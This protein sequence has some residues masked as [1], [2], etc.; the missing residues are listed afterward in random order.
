MIGKTLGHYEILEKIGQGGM[1][2][3][4]RARDT[5]LG[6]EV[7]LKTLPSAKSGDLNWRTRFQREAMAVAA[8]KHPNIVTI[9]SVEE[10]G[11]T[12]F[13][14]MEL[15][16]GQSLDYLI[17]PNG[18]NLPQLLDIAIPV[19]Q[20][21]SYAHEKGIMHRDLK[22][23]NIMRDER[24][25]LKVLDFGLAKLLEPEEGSEAATL[26]GDGGVTKEGAVI[27]TAS[28]M[29]PEQAEGKSTDARSDIFSLGILL[30]EMATGQKPFKGDTTI[31]TI[32][33]VLKDNPPL[34][35]HLN[36]SL[37]N[38]L[39]R[40]VNR[41]LAKDPGRR[42]QVALDLTNELE[43]L[44][45]ESSS[46]ESV[47]EERIA[48]SPPAVPAA[49]SAIV[50]GRSSRKR[51]WIGGGAA[52]ALAVVLGLWQPWASKDASSTGSQTQTA[53]VASSQTAR[54]GDRMMAV[55]FP[56]ENLGPSDQA[57]FA[58]GVSE[59]ITSR[60]SAVSGLGVI[61]R[62]SAV[63]YDRSGK[64]LRQVGSEL[65]VD[66][67]L[68]GTV[69]W[70]RNA[71]G[72]QRVR[73]TPQLIRAADDTRIWSESY[74]R[75]IDDIFEVQSD[76]AARVITE[77][78]VTLLGSESERLEERPT[79]NIEA[80]QA[81]LQAKELKS[82]TSSLEEFDR[83]KVSLL[84]KAT[85]LDPGFLAAWFELA[86]HH[87]GR[88]IG[89][90]R[91]ETRL[92]RA[93]EAVE[94]AEAVDPNHPFALLARGY[95]YYYG[96][97]DYDR[98]LSKFTAAS[99]VLPND[100]D[101]LEAIAYIHRRQ[102]K[103]EQAV[104]ELE[105]VVALDPENANVIG[106]LALTYG[107]LRRFEP[108]SRLLDRRLELE[109][110]NDD[111]ALQKAMALI[112]WKGDVAGARSALR[113]KP[114][115]NPIYLY[116]RWLLDTFE[117]DYAKALEHAERVEPSIPFIRV[118]RMS[119]VAETKVRLKGA[120]GASES[121]AELVRACEELL[122][123][124]PSNTDVRGWLAIAHAHLGEN[125]AAVSE[126]KLAVELEAKDL[127]SG[128]EQLVTLARVYSLV[129]R[130]EEAVELL[131]RLLATNYNGALTVPMLQINPDW[132]A[133]REDPGFVA[134]LEK[135]GE[136]LP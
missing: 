131:D 2:E 133:L 70:A 105:N 7:A 121:L 4:Y 38:H 95:Y 115:S 49:D 116:G 63:Q 106:T 112:S 28:Y 87:S 134:L 13:L 3:V 100:T 71:D 102:G 80:Y 59:E 127:F 104:E 129:G 94:F 52:L 117:R 39:G 62:T 61:S 67:V 83:Q 108:A 64:T 16:E 33:S 81:Y 32:S 50:E 36:H 21:V 74:D 35:T 65:G 111:A 128:P 103:L 54:N 9:H 34:V 110:E 126:A 8:L 118:A 11:E 77:L 98:A 22:P 20:A 55:V 86:V 19:V 31:S 69:R 40:V 85:T 92:I 124:S 48:V 60:L 14:T 97:R 68:E 53:A 76:I 84:E 12:L 82:G 73:I 90:D 26:V 43:G 96:F 130:K 88:Y 125:S 79:D 10:D 57:Y 132:D 17:P 42:Y 109:P 89:L 37:P 1:G 51:L 25:H 58:A 107:A 122:E 99:E 5:K 120:D 136:K 113:E 72:T 18:L 47:I 29:S 91:T 44:R 75:Q 119:L 15:V 101:V 66:Y 93:K 6:R 114:G 135:Y 46:S 123:N 23:Q 30:Y 41:C 27:G 45:E 24:G 56:F 78:G